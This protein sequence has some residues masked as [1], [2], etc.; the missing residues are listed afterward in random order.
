MDAVQVRRI[1][2]LRVNSAICR[3]VK[4][5]VYGRPSVG[6]RRFARPL[7]SPAL[8]DFRTTLKILN[9]RGFRPG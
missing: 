1:G 2:F 4:E 7:E 3:R 6:A 9:P 5:Y 8:E